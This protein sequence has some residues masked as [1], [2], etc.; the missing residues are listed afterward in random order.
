MGDSQVWDMCTLYYTNLFHFQ[1]GVTGLG[2]G[3]ATLE[4]RPEGVGRLSQERERLSTCGI[5]GVGLN[6]HAGPGSQD[7]S[8]SGEIAP[9]TKH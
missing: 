5:K 2:R 8:S 3:S 4:R 9:C 6:V 7:D 1:Q